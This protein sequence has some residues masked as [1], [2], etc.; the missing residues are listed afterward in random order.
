MVKGK[1]VTLSGRYLLRAENIF[2]S[3][4]SLFIHKKKQNFT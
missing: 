1:A 3:E 4:P 2:F